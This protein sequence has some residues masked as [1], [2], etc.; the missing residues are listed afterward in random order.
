MRVRLPRARRV[1]ILAGERKVATII[2][3][4]TA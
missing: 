2:R 1:T 3:E 4:S